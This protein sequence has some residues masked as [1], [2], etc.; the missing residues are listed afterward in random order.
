MHL[1]S[2][3]SITNYCTDTDKPNLPYPKS[4][5]D[6][7]N[8]NKE[9]WPDF[10]TISNEDQHLLFCESVDILCLLFKISRQETGSVDGCQVAS[11]LL[12]PGCQLTQSMPGSGR[13]GKQSKISGELSPYVRGSKLEVGHWIFH[14]GHHWVHKLQCNLLWWWR[15]T[16]PSTR[17]WMEPVAEFKCDC[18]KV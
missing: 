8:Y 4:S 7:Q 17:C 14:P 10:F 1:N 18:E 13:A 3:I 6:F 16:S 9:P 5:L 11:V 12:D 15:T 2:R